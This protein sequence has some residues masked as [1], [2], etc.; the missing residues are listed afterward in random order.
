MVADAG[1][2]GSISPAPPPMLA[3]TNAAKAHIASNAAAP[4]HDAVHDRADPP[5]GRGWYQDTRACVGIGRRSVAASSSAAPEAG[6]ARRGGDP[7]DPRM[8]REVGERVARPR[9]ARWVPARAPPCDT[10]SARRARR[11]GRSG[12]IVLQ[13][14][15]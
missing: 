6:A 7:A 9:G 3:A 15:E 13:V 14:L 4:T 5:A 2:E 11:G 10:P 8:S 1:E 12:V